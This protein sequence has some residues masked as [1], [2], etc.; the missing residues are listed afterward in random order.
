MDNYFP[1]PKIFETQANIS[2]SRM[3][4]VFCPSAP[5]ITLS[6]SLVT[7]AHLKNSTAAFASSSSDLAFASATAIMALASP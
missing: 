5:S 1:P 6:C 4:L 2:E 3:Y 7:A